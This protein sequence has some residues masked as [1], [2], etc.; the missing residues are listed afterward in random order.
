MVWKRS[1]DHSTSSE[2]PVQPVRSTAP[3]P[4]NP[5]V[6]RRTE[7][8]A[9]GPS[10]F[11][12][13]DL[14]GEEDLLIEGQVEGLVDLKQNNVTVGKSGRVKADI[15]GRVVTI[16]GEVDGNV[17]AKEQAVLKQSGTIRGNISAPRV[18]LEDGSRFKGSIDME[19]KEVVRSEPPKPEVSRPEPAAATPVGPGP[20]PVRP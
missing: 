5:E 8:A 4:G 16:E 14:A 7:R 18:V 11:I 13:G 1:D 3:Q 19:A 2:P 6:S 15:K 9:I 10:I 12:K 20:A 17:Y